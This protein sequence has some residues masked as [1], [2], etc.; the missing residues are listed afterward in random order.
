MAK[1]RKSAK[2]ELMDIF[3]SLLSLGFL[4]LIGYVYVQTKSFY[5][6]GVVF[7]VVVVLLGILA[8]LRDR[9]RNERLLRSGIAQIDK[10]DGDE[11]ERYLE[12]FFKAQGYKSIK[13]KAS[14]DFGA[15]VIIE[16]NN[17]RIA[18][19]AKRHG[20]NVGVKAVQEVVAAKAHYKAHEA[21]VVTNSE[22]TEQAVRL[23]KSNGVKL[24][25]R[26]QLIDMI[27]KS[28]GS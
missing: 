4:F 25:D 5:I 12:Q 9:F 2:D 8:G 1:R 3:A 7:V 16:K 22:Y 28:K 18:I 19:Q 27:L 23:A 13:T 10:M 26:Q 24:I 20:Q 21:W 11:F 6:T 17:I 15:D 14:G